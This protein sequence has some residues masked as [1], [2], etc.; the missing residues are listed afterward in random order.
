M[1]MFLIF[2]IGLWNGMGLNFRHCYVE[3]IMQSC[4]NFLKGLHSWWMIL[5]FLFCKRE[6]FF[7]FLSFLQSC[8]RFTKKPL[9]HEYLD[10]LVGWL[11]P[12]LWFMVSLWWWRISQL[13]FIEHFP[14]FCFGWILLSSPLL[15]FWKLKS[16]YFFPFFALWSVSG[17]IF[18]HF[19][20][21]D[22]CMLPVW[23]HS[24]YLL[25]LRK[26]PLCAF[27]MIQSSVL[28]HNN[29]NLYGH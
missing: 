8:I 19:V 13:C 18:Y 7:L 2:H 17:S 24:S 22:K 27:R 20:G 26:Q 3:V 14:C 28:M 29:L 1:W 16:M 10:L 23:L 21:L 4:H 15:V 12:S 6:K 25:F 5:P 9:M 11:H